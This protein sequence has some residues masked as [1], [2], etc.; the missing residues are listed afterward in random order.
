MVRDMVKINQDLAELVGA[1]IGDGSMG[2]YQGHPAISFVGHPEEDK[3]YINWI[4][5]RYNKYFY[6]N[7]KL[8]KWSRVL[9]FQSFSRDAFNFLISLGIPSGKKNN[10]DIPENIKK[11]RKKILAA[12]IR[13]IWDTDGTVYFEKTK[14]GLYPRLQLKI[15][16]RNLAESLYKILNESFNIKTTL[17]NRRERENWKISYFVETRGVKN[18]EMWLKD[19]GFRNIKHL[20]KIELWKRNIN[21]RIPFEARLNITNEGP[22]SHQLKLLPYAGKKH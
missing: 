8:R 12:C 1:H 15:T 19:I 11:S 22:V 10:I 6:I 2:F 20:S 4:L 14:R 13:G 21:P 17:H 16:S 9:G 3:E 18:L 7:S 5:S